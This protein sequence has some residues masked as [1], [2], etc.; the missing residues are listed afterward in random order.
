MFTASQ[1]TKHFFY[2]CFAKICQNDF[3][4]KTAFFLG[5]GGFGSRSFR[6]NFLFFHTFNFEWPL[7]QYYRSAIIDE[8]RKGCSVE[9]ASR[10]QQCIIGN[11]L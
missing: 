2:P 6:V 8:S 3:I 7:N 9:H 5:G 4:E 11:V 1:F 10:Q